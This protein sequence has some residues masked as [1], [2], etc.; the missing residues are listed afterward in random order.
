MT[1]AAA[2]S[3]AIS[4]P[5]AVARL[6]QV[7]KELN[8]A[9]PH[10]KFTLDGRLVGDIGE[11][12]VASA[13]DLELFEGVQRHHDGTC[14]K[15]RLVQVKATMKTNLTFPAGPLPW[16]PDSPRRNLHRGLQRPGG[17]RRESNIESQAPEDQPA[18]GLG[19]GAEEAQP[20]DRGARPNP[21]PRVR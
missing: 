12:L 5:M 18:L 15:G 2:P 10:K 14:S 3:P 11:V 20:G 9:Y 7:V 13:Y 19:V 1:T 16:H 21:T 8:A 17:G 4:I 6:L